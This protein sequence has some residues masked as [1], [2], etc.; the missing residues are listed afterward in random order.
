MTA[1]QLQTHLHT[2]VPPGVEFYSYLSQALPRIYDMGMW[3][4]LVDE[5]S[6]DGAVG[7]VSLPHGYESVIANTVNDYPL[8][9]NSL[10]GDIRVVG[11]QP[12]LSPLFGIVDSGFRPVLL[13]MVDVEGITDEDEL[14]GTLIFLTQLSGTTDQVENASFYGQISI[15]CTDITGAKVTL[16]PTVGTYLTYEAGASNVTR[17]DSITYS[18]VESPI[19]LVSQS[20]PDKIVTTIPAGTGVLRLRRFRVGNSDSE[21]RVHLLVKRA[22]PSE[23]T[24]DTIIHLGNIAALKHALLAQTAEDNADLNRAT[25]HWQ[26]VERILDR[27]LDA[28][29]GSARPKLSV[30]PFGANGPF[31]LY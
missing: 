13:D 18:N 10:W 30:N 7:Y 23:L 25:Y 28:F 14:V 27:E 21:T 15:Q 6:L 29:R 17:I 5:I 8:P 26:E 1:A 24:E 9:V 22:A 16:T 2:Y 11:R 19:D 12:V 4:D 31:N 3:R 20:F